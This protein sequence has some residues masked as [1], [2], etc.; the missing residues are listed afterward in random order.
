M[1]FLAVLLTGARLAAQEPQTEDGAR[2]AAMQLVKLH[3]KGVDS[4]RV[5]P[6]SVAMYRDF[7]R[8]RDIAG[9]EVCALTDNRAVHL[10]LVRLVAPDT[11][12]VEEQKYEMHTRR[13][14]GGPVFEFPRIMAGSGSTWRMVYRGGR[15]VGDG[16]GR[17]WIC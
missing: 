1:L 7:V 8:C 16:L 10:I 17:G 3:W 2:A 4:S 11:A 9:R 6:D 5:V 15:W 13:C 12:V 14:P